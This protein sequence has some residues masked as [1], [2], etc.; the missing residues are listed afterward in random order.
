MESR[1]SPEKRL[2]KEIAHNLLE[3]GIAAYRRG[4]YEATVSKCRASLESGSINEA[5]FY[6]ALA[7]EEMH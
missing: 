7:L 6:K 5:Y 3:D 4:D 2:K 1:F